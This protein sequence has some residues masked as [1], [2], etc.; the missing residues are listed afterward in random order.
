[1][2]ST[3]GAYLDTKSPAILNTSSQTK[4]KA[5]FVQGDRLHAKS[6]IKDFNALELQKF[7]SGNRT[8]LVNSELSS[9]TAIKLPNSHSMIE[10]KQA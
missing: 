2:S 8:V 5:Q 7:N 6:L 9:A 10:E 1:M 3:P 4:G